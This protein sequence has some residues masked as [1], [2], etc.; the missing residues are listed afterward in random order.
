MIYNRAVTVF[1]RRK[2]LISNAGNGDF[3]G[4][5]TLYTFKG[6]FD[7]FWRHQKRRL[8]APIRS[9]ISGI[10][11]GTFGERVAAQRKD[12]WAVF[13]LDTLENGTPLKLVKTV[14]SYLYLYRLQCLGLP[15]KAQK[16]APARCRAG[17]EKKSPWISCRKPPKPSAVLAGSERRAHGRC[18]ARWPPGKPARRGPGGKRS[19][20]LGNSGYRATAPI[21]R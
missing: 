5:M 13:P 4:G 1:C 19:P 14:R 21:V 9:A 8:D 11:R 17:A 10:G 15:P 7:G 2:S 16:R 12:V 18:P 6:T 3:R 20:V